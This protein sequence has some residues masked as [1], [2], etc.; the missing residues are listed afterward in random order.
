[1]RVD[2]S[3]AIDAPPE[4]VWELV[5]DPMRVCEL[6]AGVA[7][8]DV[9][10]ARDRGRGARY[11]VLMQVGSVPVGGLVEIVEWDEGRDIAWTSV[12]GVD[13]RGRWRL[14]RRD[15]GGTTLTLRL[16]YGAPGGLLGLLA[17]RFSAPMVRANL[18]R[19]VA[20]VRAE[21]E[22]QRTG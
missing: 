18:R 3:T 7:R 15:D 12:T 1:M 9:E 6:M 14:R 2:T 5:S 4:V 20:N 17:D 11:R 19:T 22:R 13:Q 8:W 21:A 10:G 16:S